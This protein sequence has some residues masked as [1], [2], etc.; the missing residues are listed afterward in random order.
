M[1]IV[2]FKLIWEIDSAKL[3][4]RVRDELRADW[5]PLGAP[6]LNGGRDMLGQALVK[7]EPEAL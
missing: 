5:Q 3:V 1:K 2:D 7:Y 4:R 6:F